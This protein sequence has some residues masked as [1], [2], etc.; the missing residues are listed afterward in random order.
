MDPELGPETYVFC[1]AGRSIEQGVRLD[2]WALIREAE[3]W[4]AI[5]EREVAMAERLG[6]QAEFRRITLKV[7]SSLEAVGLTAAVATALAQEGIS[8]NV[9]AAFH[10]DHVFVPAGQAV[11][12]MAVL[13]MTFGPGP[14]A[15]G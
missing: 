13:K 6:Y 3:G 9:V 1:E 7:N 14:R 10:H 2:P 15:S 11:A 5:L 4:T 12:A 8:A